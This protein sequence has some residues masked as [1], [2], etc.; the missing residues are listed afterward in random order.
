M[1]VVI[2][3]DLVISA[4]SGSVFPLNY[5]RIGYQSY[6]EEGMLTYDAGSPVSGYPLENILTGQTFE[7]A[8]F[9]SVAVQINIDLGQIQSVD[10][11]AFVSKNAINYTLQYS[12]DGIDYT[13]VSQ[14]A[15]SSK[16]ARMALFD[17]ITARYWRVFIA[18]PLGTE[19]QIT[20]LKLGLALAMYR[21]IYGGHSP[22][23]LNRLTAK[24]PTR[25]EGGEFLSSSIT[26]QGFAGSFDYR[27]LPADWYRDFFDPFVEHAR[28]GTY[29]IA[30]NPLQFPKEVAYG[31]T[32]ED[33]TP[34]N[35]GIRDLMQV[36]W[37]MRGYDAS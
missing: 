4:N 29:Y 21:P 34:S 2:S 17:S 18:S 28:T 10:Y 35:M 24:T 7:V 1:P 3:Q 8:K 15:D 6:L 33:F 14:A 30:W 12:S 27:H 22:I 32:E 13:A 9:D 25:S 26:R 11:M 20:N 31:W 5:A 16:K 37:N 19:V 36:S 23:T